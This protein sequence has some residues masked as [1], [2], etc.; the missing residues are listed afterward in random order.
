MWFI[1]FLGQD[2]DIGRYRYAYFAGDEADHPDPRSTFRGLHMT[3]DGAMQRAAKEIAWGG[4]EWI[5]IIDVRKWEV[6]G[7]WPDL[8]YD[9]DEE[10][11]SE[12]F[13]WC[14]E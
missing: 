13:F 12:D 11:G 7:D 8:D 6:V 5:Q 10:V 9:P 4:R 14:G 1:M 3:L 2:G